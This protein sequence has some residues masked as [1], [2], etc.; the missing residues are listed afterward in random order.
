MR[1]ESEQLRGHE[2]SSG[3]VPGHQVGDVI[4]G[5][6]PRLAEDC[7]L[8]VVMQV[9]IEE[10]ATVWR[11]IPASEGASGLADVVLGVIA[12]AHGEQLHELAGVVLVG[13]ATP[14]CPEVE[15]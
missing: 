5:Q 14:I 1:K 6:W 13:R 10:K 4:A 11:A 8:A 2:A 3:R 15:P 9:M 12:D 7:L